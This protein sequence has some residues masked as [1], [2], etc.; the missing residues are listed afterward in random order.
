MRVSQAIDES[1]RRCD[2]ASLVDKQAKAAAEGM[3]AAV[4]KT[5]AAEDLRRRVERGG[6]LSIA[7]ASAGAQP[8]LAALLRQSFP[9]RALVAVVDGVKAQEAFHQDLHTWLAAAH[10]NSDKLPAPL[11]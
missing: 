5:P 6:V 9:Q 4:A 2:G 11:F 1:L 3:F 10:P 7:G 8:F